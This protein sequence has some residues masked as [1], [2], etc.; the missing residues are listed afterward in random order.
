[1]MGRMNNDRECIKVFILRDGRTAVGNSALGMVEAGMYIA[2]GFILNGSMSGGGGS[3]SQS[4]ASA[5]LFFVLGQV[6]LLA[7]GLVYET[8]TPFHVRDE[9]RQNNLAAGIGLAGILVALA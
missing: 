5:L 6:V 2:T 8:I 3:F 4:L 1:M 7:F 9:I